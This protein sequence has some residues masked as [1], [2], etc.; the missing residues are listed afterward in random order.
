MDNQIQFQKV[1]DDSPR[2]PGKKEGLPLLQAGKKKK[3]PKKKER[4]KKKHQPRSLPQSI[5]FSY[6]NNSKRN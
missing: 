1:G 4:K 3:P 5:T 6:F 2:T